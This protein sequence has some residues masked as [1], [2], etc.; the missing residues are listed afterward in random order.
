MPLTS[1]YVRL[2]QSGHQRWKSR[3]CSPFRGED[4]PFAGNTLEGL[5]TAVTEAQTGA[6]HEVF[7]CAR[8][9][10]FARTG[11]RCHPRADVHGNAAHVVTHHFALACVKTGTHFDSERPD[12]FGYSASATHAARRTIKSS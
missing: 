12:L 2:T 3:L 5:T 6:R 11:K 7:D 9:K 10:D 1:A 8:Y 4:V